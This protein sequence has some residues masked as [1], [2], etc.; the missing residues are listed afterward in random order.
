[1]Q[2]EFLSTGQ[3]C[4]IEFPLKPVGAGRQNELRDDMQLGG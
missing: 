1:V 2:R 3:V 4:T